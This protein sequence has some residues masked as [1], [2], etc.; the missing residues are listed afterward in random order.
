M[1]RL[2][3]CGALALLLVTGCKTAPPTKYYTLNMESSGQAQAPLNL[4]VDRIQVGETLSRRDIMVKQSP[5][6]I[7]YY[8]T[9]QWA[10]G[11]D[12]LVSRKLQEEFGHPASGR[13]TLL[14]QGTVLAFE[15]ID[16]PGGADAHVRLA[17]DI[18]DETSSRHDPP[19]MTK[20]YTARKKADTEHP[21]DVV[22]ALSQLLETI[23]RE[24]VTDVAALP[25]AQA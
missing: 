22:H 9:D 23:A 6:Q 13:P 17:V 25:A 18:R 15:Q 4:S 2:F 21:R 14:L 11:L 3:C 10:A 1:K 5:T 16:V 7:E 20:V 12:E 24:I 8:A 19:L